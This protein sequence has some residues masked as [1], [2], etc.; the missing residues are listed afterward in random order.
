MSRLDQRS[1]SE[2]PQ[3]GDTKVRHASRSKGQLGYHLTGAASRKKPPRGPLSGKVTAQMT[4][5]A[6]SWTGLAPIASAPGYVAVR[7]GHTALTSTGV[8]DSSAANVAV[9]AFSAALLMP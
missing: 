2:R 8:S 9:S 7:P 6:S 3:G 1:R 5:R 4:L